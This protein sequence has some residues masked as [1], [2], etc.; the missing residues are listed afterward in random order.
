[1]TVPYTHRC[2]AYPA[3]FRPGMAYCPRCRAL[4]LMERGVDEELPLPAGFTLRVDGEG[5]RTAASPRA[6]AGYRDAGLVGGSDEPAPA[7]IVRRWRHR[8]W[9]AGCVLL[10]GGSVPALIALLMLG[11]IVGLFP[12]TIHGS[13]WATLGPAVASGAILYVALTI[14][15]NGTEVAIAPRSVVR[16]DRPLPWGR[17]ARWERRPGDRVITRAVPPGP[18]RG[19]SAL[20]TYQVAIASADGAR[21]LVLFDDLRWSDEAKQMATVVGALL[22]TTRAG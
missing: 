8:W 21:Q 22:E 14:L 2:G 10:F 1:M 7:R 19:S 17:T 18:V 11:T 15:L 3:F 9:G 6:G 16:T 5:S 12:G 13:P 20:E 4:L